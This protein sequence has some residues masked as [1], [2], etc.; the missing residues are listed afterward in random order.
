LE[1]PSIKKLKVQLK[2][3]EKVYIQF[4]RDA[5]QV[6]SRPEIVGKYFG[7]KEFSNSELDVG[8]WASILAEALGCLNEEKEYQGRKKQ[9]VTLANEPKKG[10]KTREMEV[11]PH[12]WICKPFELSGDVASNLERG[13]A[14][15]KPVYEWVARVSS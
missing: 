12:L 15:L 7:G 5:W 13:I 2:H 1:K 4:M 8:I 14:Q 6:T 3:P 11:S 9:L 10:E